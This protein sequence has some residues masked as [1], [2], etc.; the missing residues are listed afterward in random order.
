MHIAQLIRSAKS[1]SDWTDNELFAFNIVIQDVDVATFFGAPQLPLTTVSPIILN[2]VLQPAP[3]AVISKEDRL[4]FTYLERANTGEEAP[5]DDFSGHILRM[6]NF[7]DDERSIATKRELSF[8]M[9]GTRVRAKADIAV[10]DNAEYSLMVQNDKVVAVGSSWGMSMS[11]TNVKRTTVTDE[12]K[13]QLIAEVIA[14]FVENNRFRVPPLPQQTFPAITMVGPCPIFYKIPVTQALV[15]ALITSQYPVQPTI[16][17]RLVP[18]VP[19]PNSY[20]RH[21]MNPLENRGIVF[22][23]L[24][25]MRALLVS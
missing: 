10:L 20:R 4:F 14:A 7:D 15:D 25:A 19:D 21:G 2:N 22:Q 18:P 24:E 6:L 13:P 9:C 5:V 23:C 11:L 3:P 8:T 1:G 16:V 17:Q 12:P